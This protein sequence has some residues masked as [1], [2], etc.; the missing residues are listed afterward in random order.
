MENAQSTPE[1]KQT[2]ESSTAPTTPD[3]SPVASEE[4]PLTQATT[5]VTGTSSQKKKPLVLV[6][7]VII[8]LLGLSYVAYGAFNK[9]EDKTAAT[10]E[11][12]QENPDQTTSVQPKLTSTTFTSGL[13][14]GSTVSFEH[15]IDW[16]IIE[17]EEPLED[18][19]IALKSLVIGSPDGNYM[20]IYDVH[21]IGGYCEPNQDTYTLF[22]K[23]P[24]R[25]PDH[26]FKVYEFP[27]NPS[28]SRLVFFEASNQEWSVVEHDNLEE[29]ESLTNTCNIP[30]YP[31]LAASGVFISLHNTSDRNADGA[32][33]LSWEDIKYDTAF[34]NMLG[35]VA[36]VDKSPTQNE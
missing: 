4:A 15:P 12:S 20:H 25:T 9:A 29:G 33:Q 1:P 27:A 2:P 23:L 16:T 36:G 11:Q 13:R 34:Q 7:I 14:G 35:S 8:V 32:R 6:L 10:Q 31:S 22:M 5:V 3:V 24:T 28:R 19:G 17:N 26:Y 30:S 18:E 21:G